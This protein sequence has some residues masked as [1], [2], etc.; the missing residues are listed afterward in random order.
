MICCIA[1]R[2]ATRIDYCLP[3]IPLRIGD[4]LTLLHRD[5]DWERHRK[6]DPA[7]KRKNSPSPGADNFTHQF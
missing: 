1:L 6:D 2:L 7:G 4:V 3:G 5:V